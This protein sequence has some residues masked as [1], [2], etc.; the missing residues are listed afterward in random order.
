MLINK[1][2]TKSNNISNKSSA[3]LL[4]NSKIPK[5]YGHKN[6]QQSTY[7]SIQILTSNHITKIKRKIQL[8]D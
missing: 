6:K 7:T 1:F 3:R 4:N 5:I 2:R 8:N